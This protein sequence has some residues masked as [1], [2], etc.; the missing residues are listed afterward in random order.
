MGGRVLPMSSKGTILA[1]RKGR[2]EAAAFLETILPGGFTSQVQGF[3]EARRLAGSP[4]YG[5]TPPEEPEADTV[6]LVSN[7]VPRGG[8]LLYGPAIIDEF[9]RAFRLHRIRVHTVRIDDAGPPAEEVMK[10]IAEATGGTYVH[11]MKP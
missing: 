9:R 2:R 5:S 4:C 11:Q 8:P 3:W 6:I 1:N 10:G 7:G